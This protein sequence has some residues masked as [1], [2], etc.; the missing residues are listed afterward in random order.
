MGY[1]EVDM[2]EILEVLRRLGRA[3]PIAAIKLATGR[4][5]KTIRRYGKLAAELGWV[6]GA[7]EPTEELAGAIA[8]RLRPVPSKLPPGPVEQQLLPEQEGIR[9]WLGIDT[10]ERGLRLTKVH[11]LLERRG[12]TVPYSSLHRFAVKYCGFADRRRLTVRMALC[13]PGELAEVDFGRWAGLGSRGGASPRA[14]RADHHA[15]LQP[16]PVRLRPSLAKAARSPR[17]TGRRQGLL[18]GGPGSR[19]PRQPQSGG[20]QERP[21]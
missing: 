20:R 9:E 6:P 1:R 3:E 21:L 11:R 8:L 4:S 10:P 7:N 15:G 17:R 19:G 18:C 13:Q 16:P 2:W 5:R 12:I 14:A